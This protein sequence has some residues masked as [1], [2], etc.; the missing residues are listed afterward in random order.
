MNQLLKKDGHILITLG[1][2]SMK[3]VINKNFVGAP[4]A[5]SSYSVEQNKKMVQKA[6]FEILMM[7]EDK[8]TIFDWFL[9]LSSGT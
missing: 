8:R 4:M 5:W 3:M 7:V 6:G 2:E 1:A 9:F